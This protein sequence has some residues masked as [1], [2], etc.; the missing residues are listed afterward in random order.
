MRA[1]PNKILLKQDLCFDAKIIKIIKI[2]LLGVEENKYKGRGSIIFIC[3]NLA[4]PH[5]LT[6]RHFPVFSS[7][8]L[9]RNKLIKYMPLSFNFLFHESVC[10]TLYMMPKLTLVSLR[11]IHFVITDIMAN[12]CLGAYP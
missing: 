9:F 10:F 3:W 7:K 6:Y 12:V 11:W 4:L 1:C 5:S 2:F 8:I